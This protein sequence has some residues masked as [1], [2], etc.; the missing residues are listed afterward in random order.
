MKTFLML[1]GCLLGCL[2]AFGQEENNGVDVARRLSRSNPDSA[3]HYYAR[4]L[5]EARANRNKTVEADCLIGMGETLFNAGNYVQATDFLTAAEKISREIANPELVALTLNAL[6][7]LYYYNR[8][9][10][11]ANHCFE[12]ALQVFSSLKNDSGLAETYARIGQVYEKRQ[13]LDSAAWFQHRALQYGLKT[14]DS[15][16]VAKIYENI[17][18]I[19]E[20][21]PRYDS[22]MYYYKRSNAW[23]ESMGNRVDRLEVINNIGD[24]YR[25]TGDVRTGLTYTLMAM[26]LSIKLNHKYQLNAAYRDL[27]KSYELLGK[28]DSAYFMMEK[29]RLAMQEVYANDNNTQIAM[30][31]VLFET[32][33]KD[34]EITRLEQARNANRFMMISAAIVLFLLLALS[35]FI[36]TR[37]KIKLASERE[38]QRQKEVIYQKERGLMEAELQNRQLQQERLKTDLEQNSRELSSQLLHVIQKN[39][40]LDEIKTGITSILKD[41]RRDQKK[42]LRELLQRVNESYSS[43]QYWKEFRNIFDQLHVSFFAGLQRRSIELTPTDL[44]LLSLIK[45]NLKPNEIATILGIT[46]D[47]LRVSRYRVKKKL[48]LEAEESLTGFL[49]SI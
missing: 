24:V 46:S 2:F 31:R 6:G 45:M 30:M 33:Q 29:S 43:D 44:R 16:A 48:G 11:L 47:S 26:E 5:S 19:F 23:Y 14:R 7:V 20:D 32:S 38:I 13:L 39:E 1:A 27:A 9:Q 37:Q 3:F 40:A 28:Y 42:Q 25:K 36:Y 17:G 4:Q 34:A 10:A 21:M 49:H 15:L 12:E 8:Q 18:S 22:A 35:Y 41:E